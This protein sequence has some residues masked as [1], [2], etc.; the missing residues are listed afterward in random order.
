[1]ARNFDSGI[2]S[3]AELIACTALSIAGRAKG[4]NAVAMIQGFM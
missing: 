1:M 2:R 4:I 3:M